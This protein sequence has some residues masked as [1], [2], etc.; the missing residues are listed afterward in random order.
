MKSSDQGVFLSIKNFDPG[1]TE[2]FEE[3]LVASDYIYPL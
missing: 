1:R 2:V 3:V